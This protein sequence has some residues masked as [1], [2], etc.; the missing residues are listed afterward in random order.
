MKLYH[1][2]FSSNAR[3]A[4]LTAKHLGTPVELVFLDLAKGENL[5]PEFLKL[6][7]NHKVP[8]LVDGELALWEAHAIMIYLAEKTP[9]QTLYPATPEGRADV[10]RWMFWSAYHFT[11]AVGVLNWEHI[12]KK[13]MGAGEPDA[14]RVAE[15]EKILHG[16]AAILDAHLAD[17][18]Y[19]CGA[20][21]TLADVAIACPLMTT[22][23]AKLPV[24]ELANLQRWFAKI[25]ALP[26]W[27]ATNP[28]M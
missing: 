11:P 5:K 8:T 12:I 18:E 6:N 25:Q 7:P 14:A 24:T 15:H 23:P 10:N 21:L 13:M 9:G 22:V 26:A 28:Q 16:L 17:R 1:H 3:K 19:V 27:Q 2:P 4:V 20:A